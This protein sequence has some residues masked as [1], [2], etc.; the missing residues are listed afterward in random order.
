MFFTRLGNVKWVGL[1]ELEKDVSFI[2]CACSGII[3]V[4]IKLK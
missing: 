1:T 2:V 4:E 3:R